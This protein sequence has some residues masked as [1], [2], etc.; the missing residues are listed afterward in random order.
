MPLFPK[1][2]DGKRFYNPNAAQV[3]GLLDVLRWKMTSRP[4]PSPRFLN[5]VTPSVPPQRISGPELRITL[6]NHSTVL[7]Q[8]QNLN[9]LT[10]PMWAE[11]ASPIQFIGPRRR[12]APGVRKANLPPIDLVLLSHNHYD[13]LD[14]PMLRWLARHGHSTFIV[15]CGLARLLH[16]EKIGPL[17]ELDWG[18]SHSIAGIAV[19]AVPALHFSARGL[20]DRNKSLWCGYVL[21]LQRSVY[22]AADTGFGDHFAQ[23]REAFDSPQIALLPIGA[24]APEWFMSPIHMGPADAIRAQEI[25][26]AETAIAIHHGTFQLADDGVDTPQAELLSRVNSNSFRVLKNGEFLEFAP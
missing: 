1:H 9:I 3:R 14:L 25:L 6:V 4:E 19:H 16:R 26:G 10:D 11:R 24:Y 13:H 18:D 7:L 21:E 5:D 17:H 2:F 23:I 8:Q 20:F 22:F 15:P 12:R